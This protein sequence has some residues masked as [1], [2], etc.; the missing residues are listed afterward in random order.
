MVWSWEY[1]QPYCHFGD[2]NGLVVNNESLCG[3]CSWQEILLRDLFID[4]SPELCIVN[5]K[6]AK[7]FVWKSHQARWR[8]GRK[9]W[10]YNFKKRAY[11]LSIA[12]VPKGITTP[13][14]SYKAVA[15]YLH[16]LMTGA[17]LGG[18]VRWWEGRGSLG[19]EENCHY[20]LSEV[21]R[22]TQL[23]AT[24]VLSY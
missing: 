19:R 24:S 15:E 11:F 6:E 20:W 21:I 17:E 10:L 5:T 9:G 18:Q 3:V 23:W 12:F 14:S 1:W 4:L 16:Q 7:G 8:E 22:D 2:F 13:Q